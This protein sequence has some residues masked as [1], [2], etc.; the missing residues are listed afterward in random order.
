MSLSVHIESDEGCKKCSERR[1]QKSLFEVGIRYNLATGN[2]RRIVMRFET[3]NIVMITYFAVLVAGVIGYISNI[4]KLIHLAGGS[5]E[6]MFVLRAIGV[7]VPPFGG[8]MGW[9]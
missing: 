3:L 6:A 7:F 2:F 4:V 8:V 9:L 5:I 1:P